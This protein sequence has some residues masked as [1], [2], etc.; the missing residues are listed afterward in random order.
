MAA[1]VIAWLTRGTAKK[2]QDQV[3]Q[4]QVSVDGNL[5]ALL[6][7]NQTLSDRNLDLEKQASTEGTGDG[8]QP[9]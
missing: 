9:K 6:G 2:T 4:F 3:T 1:A 5:A 8:T 7:R